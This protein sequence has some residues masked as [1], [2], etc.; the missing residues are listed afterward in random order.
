MLSACLFAATA[1][2]GREDD[3]DL[4][5]WFAEF[6]VDLDQ[7]LLRGNGRLWTSIWFKVFEIQQMVFDAYRLSQATNDP[8]LAELFEKIPR[9]SAKAKASAKPKAEAKG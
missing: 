4:K 5:T 1:L 8:V 3:D 9:S 6:A 7:V 2:Q